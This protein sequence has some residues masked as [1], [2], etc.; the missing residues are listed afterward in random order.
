MNVFSSNT[1]SPY[2]APFRIRDFERRESERI[3][4]SWANIVYDDSNQKVE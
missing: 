3:E 2:V 1:Y 4:D